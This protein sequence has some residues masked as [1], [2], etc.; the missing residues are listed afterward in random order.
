VGDS[1]GNA[2]VETMSDLYKAGVIHR[3]GIW[4]NPHVVEMAT[5]EWIHWF[6]HRRLLGPLGYV[7]LAE[8]ED[9]YYET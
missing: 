3:L 5:R 8:A 6:N 4:R 2:L 1:Y 7:S 9:A